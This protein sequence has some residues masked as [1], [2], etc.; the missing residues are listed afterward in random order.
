MSFLNKETGSHLNKFLY[1][2]GTVVIA[3]LGYELYQYILR[4][5]NQLIT[6]TVNGQK[7][8]KKESL[9]IVLEKL[10]ELTKDEITQLIIYYRN[11]R[12]ENTDDIDKYEIT[13]SKMI[14]KLEKIINEKLYLILSSSN[15]SKKTFD[16]SLEL[17]IDDKKIQ[18]DI[19]QLRKIKSPSSENKLDSKILLKIMNFYEKINNQILE[20]TDIHAFD[21]KILGYQIEDKIWVE[22]GIEIDDIDFLDPIFLD[23]P[24]IKTKL[25]LITKNLNE[26]K[27]INS[28]FIN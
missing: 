21:P 26:I 28:S 10:R 16:I 2:G 5:K 15:V 12:R 7:I 22:F 17:Y 8:L 23:D 25:K 6:V 19:C 18:N 3:K 27:G 11:Q 1:L 13:V 14:K 24:E 4:K 9:L 20:S